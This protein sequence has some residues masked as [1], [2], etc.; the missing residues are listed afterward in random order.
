MGDSILSATIPATT[1]AKHIF[2]KYFA[3]GSRDRHAC[4]HACICARVQYI[5]FC[6]REYSV[7]V[8]CNR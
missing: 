7:Q 6:S 4:M 2:L 8:E 1:E 5:C 3:T